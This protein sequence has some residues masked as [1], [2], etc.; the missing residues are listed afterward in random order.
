MPLFSSA[1]FGQES[2]AKDFEAHFEGQDISKPRARKSAQQITQCGGAIEISSLPRFDGRAQE[3]RKPLPAEVALRDASLEKKSSSSTKD[4]LR[5]NSVSRLNDGTFVAV[6]GTFIAAAIEQQL[7]TQHQ[8]FMGAP[9]SKMS[10]SLPQEMA[11]PDASPEKESYITPKFQE[12]GIVT[13]SSRKGSP[14]EKSRYPLLNIFLRASQAQNGSRKNHKEF[15]PTLSDSNNDHAYLMFEE[16]KSIKR[17]EAIDG[18]AALYDSSS[19]WESV[20]SG[21]SSNGSRR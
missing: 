17:S 9:S 14:Y 19:E 15:D 4:F 16:D 3:V 10:G 5:R 21:M 11:P 1:M 6:A 12:N 7:Q 2:A 18:L 8:V 20:A 13:L